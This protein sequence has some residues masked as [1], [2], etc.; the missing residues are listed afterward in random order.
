MRALLPIIGAILLMTTASNS[1]AACTNPAAVEGEQVY[2]ADYATMQFCDGTN[3]IGMAA[4]GSA[5]AELD[6]KVGALTA[7]NFCKA[8]P[9]ATQVIC[10]TPAISLTTDITGNLPVANLGSGTGASA[11]TFWRGDGAWATPSSSQWLNGTAGK[12]YYSGGNVGIGTTAPAAP[13]QVQI[14][15]D[16]TTKKPLVSIGNALA[17]QN[18]DYVFSIDAGK[19]LH[20][21]SGSAGNRLNFD[22]NTG[23]NVFYIN[24]T[25]QGYFAGN[26]GIGTT[27]PTQLLHVNGT[28]YATTFLHTS[29]R[30]LKTEIQS[31]PTAAQLATKLRGV[32]FKWKK[33]GVPAYG[34]IAQEVEA[35]IPDAVTT[36]VDGTK[37]VDYDQLI[38]VLI[39]AVKALQVEVDALKR[40]RAQ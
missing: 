25:G 30:R 27:A 28:A 22:S 18:N 38:P 13:M 33:D 35:V 5:T 32:H 19:Q 3:W 23:A 14:N 36:N 10:S 31:I 15:A 40:E 20:L 2:N 4:S 1:Y 37:A 8:H 9:G 7:N 6:P 16:A 39:E 34:V 12:I 26:V 21:N 24:N 17:G 29:D 11:S